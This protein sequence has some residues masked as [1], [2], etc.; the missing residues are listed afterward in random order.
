MR[1]D[2][3]DLPWSVALADGRRIQMPMRAFAELLRPVIEWVESLSA[4]RHP[5]MTRVQAA[6]LAE[7]LGLHSAPSLDSMRSALRAVMD[8]AL[9]PLEAAPP[10]FT[11][12]LRH[13]QQ[14]GVHWLNSLASGGFGGVLADDMGLGKTVQV[15]AHI[16]SQ[17][18]TDP[19]A[20][21]CLIVAPKTVLLNWKPEFERF[22]PGLKVLLLDGFSRDSLFEQI[23]AHDVV[24]TH[25]ALLPRDRE[26]LRKHRFSLVVLDEA[27]MVK[28]PAT[29]AAETLRNL[30]ASRFLPVTG[31]PLENHMSELWTHLSLAVPSLMP[32]LKQFRS[33]YELPI[34]RGADP[35]R[36]AN[37]KR[38]IAPFILR[39]TKDQVATEL[40]PKTEIV[41]WVELPGSTRRLY[42]VM[43][44]AQR[45]SA[46]EAVRNMTT[47][48]AQ[49]FIL[50][51]LM[52]LR[53]VCC[54]ARLCA[55]AMPPGHSLPSETPK[56]DALILLL[57]KA[58]EDG[59][60]ILVFSSFAEMVHLIADR[61]S[62]ERIRHASMTGQTT[63]RASVLK[64]FR[65]GAA[66]VLVM[67]TQTGGVGL[68]LTEA[69]TVIH[70]D[71]WWNP[72]R[73]AQATDRVHRIGQDKPVFVHKLVCSQ[74]IE[75]RILVA[76]QAKSQLAHSLLDEGA[77]IADERKLTDLIDL[78]GA[79]ESPD[80]EDVAA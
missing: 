2:H 24:L 43:R 69:D 39:R 47:G 19:D 64:S 45:A 5:R 49:V 78:L 18:W 50:T 44:A 52:R 74:T 33:I 68:N 72:A 16:A 80:T 25:Y 58:I 51:A 30:D 32:E 56:L 20:P 8:A 37:L 26:F 23:P 61:L 27:Q 79:S 14:I 15:I 71:P 34:T 17:R 36:L 60:K 57:R 38:M 1:S 53:Q 70:Y 4:R 10:G 62:R 35:E 73:E 21:P 77:T 31:T 3:G 55:A 7:S 22:A 46:L 63:D 29:L 40:P 11:G 65:F 12:E 42:E 41:E 67:T 54:D 66:D 59:R 76:Q 13:Y 28:N 9:R 75:D 6:V 48:Q